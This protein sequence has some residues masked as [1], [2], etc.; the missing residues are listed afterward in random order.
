MCL[1]P[2]ALGIFD[3]GKVLPQ[4]LVRGKSYMHYSSPILGIVV[5]QRENRL[6]VHRAPVVA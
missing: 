5:Q 3:N 1:V 6:V 4:L 2:R